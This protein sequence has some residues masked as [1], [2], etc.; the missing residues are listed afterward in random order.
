LFDKKKILLH[1]M[2]IKRVFAL[3]LILVFVTI[4]WL[5]VM[6]FR[7]QQILVRKEMKTYIKHGVPEE[8]RLI[9][10]ADELESDS[11]NLTWIHEWEF[12]YHGEMYDILEK[13]VVD[14]QMM[15]VCIHDV[16]ESGLF[17]KLDEMVAGSMQSNI[18]V[19]QQRKMFRN[20]FNSMFFEC[21]IFQQLNNEASLL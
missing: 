12:R 7:Y 18:P 1:I 15:Y 17:A 16:K 10:N 20:F 5:P 9:F 4:T 3:A 13:K 14:G 11:D 8:E 6:V 19:Q 21:F 2:M